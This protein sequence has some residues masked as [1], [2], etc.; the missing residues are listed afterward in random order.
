MTQRILCWS[1][2][3]LLGGQKLLWDSLRGYSCA[4][5]LK[6]VADITHSAVGGVQL[7]VQLERVLHK[8][9][10]LRR[11]AHVQCILCIFSTNISTEY[12]KHAAHSPFFL[13]KMP[14][15]S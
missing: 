7:K 12:F 9:L 11:K 14:F 3:P 2:K 13:F 5:F 4:S 8:E 10:S 6:I 15:I 1:S